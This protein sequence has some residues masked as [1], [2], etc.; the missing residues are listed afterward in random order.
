M[1]L[2]VEGNVFAVNGLMKNS[3][4]GGFHI[5]QDAVSKLLVSEKQK[6]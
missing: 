5:L 3:Y 1:I 6:Y 4:L 2:P